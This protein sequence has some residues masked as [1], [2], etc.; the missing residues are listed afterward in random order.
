MLN[1]QE[2]NLFNFYSEIENKIKTNRFQN[3]LNMR[4]TVKNSV[5]N[6]NALQKVY[7][8]RLDEKRSH[9]KLET[10]A[11]SFEKQPFITS[12]RPNFEKLI[13]KSK[14]NFYK[15]NFYKFNFLN[16]FNIFY[17]TQTCLNYNIFDF[18]FLLAYKS[19]AS[20]YL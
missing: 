20:R 18:P 2:N 13:G 12:N 14:F 1:Q 16:N 10:F 6:F 4:N 15:F 7:K 8:S 3:S 5:V 9:T 11:K 19:D 17:N